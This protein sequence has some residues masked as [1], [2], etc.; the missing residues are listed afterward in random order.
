M[1]TG[2]TPKQQRFVDEYLID[3]NAKQA[4]IRSGY[5]KKTAK[6]QGQRLLGNV[7]VEAA[8][9]A[10]MDERSRATGITAEW[11]LLQLHNLANGNILDFI[12]IGEDGLPA[13]D[14]SNLTRDQAAALRGLNATPVADG[15]VRWDIK[16]ADKKAA[17][18]LLGKHLG[19][20]NQKHEITGPGGGPIEVAS[21]D[22][23]D[24]ARRIAFILTAATR[25]QDK[26]K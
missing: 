5:S 25:A 26:V 10:R 4:A 9:K 6:S 17:L 12:T 19:M 2:L 18:E 8:I 15:S 22:S 11:V 20:F 23:L 21:A 14:L 16:L 24:L 1:A 13:L 7:E 3:L